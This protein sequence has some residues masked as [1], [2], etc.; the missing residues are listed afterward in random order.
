M[1]SVRID[2]TYSKELQQRMKK[3]W[4]NLSLKTFELRNFSELLCHGHIKEQQS[5]SDG[6]WKESVPERNYKCIWKY[7]NSN[8]AGSSSYFLTVFIQNGK[9]R[10]R[11]N[12]LMKQKNDAATLRIAFSCFHRNWYLVT[13]K[14]ANLQM[15]PDSLERFRW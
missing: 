11:I 1:N 2:M 3:Y 12:L 10:I 6:Y 9:K 7:S 5:F 8:V 15:S 13:W 4:T 14:R